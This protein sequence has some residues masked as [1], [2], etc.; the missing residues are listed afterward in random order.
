LAEGGGDINFCIFS[1]FQHFSYKNGVQIIIVLK[2]NVRHVYSVTMLKDISEG[3]EKSLNFVRNMSPM[4][5][6]IESSST[7]TKWKPCPEIFWFSVWT[8]L[9][10]PSSH[11]IFERN[12]YMKKALTVHRLRRGY[13]SFVDLDG[14]Y[15][16]SHMTPVALPQHRAGA[17]PNKSSSS[18]FLELG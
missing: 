10:H 11:G 12:I 5:G 13:M 7:N 2:L 8:F 1:S 16:V 9:G 18:Q 15:Q 4:R 6:G 3:V 17:C 14:W